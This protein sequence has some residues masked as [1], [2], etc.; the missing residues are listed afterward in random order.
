MG[1]VCGCRARRLVVVARGRLVDVRFDA[2]RFADNRL[3]DD[4][5][6]AD[7]LADDRFKTDPLDRFADRFADVFADARLADARFA[8]RFSGI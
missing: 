2:D 5:L 7:R 4:R 6:P 1:C 8:V 3:G